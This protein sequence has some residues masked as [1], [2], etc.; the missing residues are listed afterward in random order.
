LILGWLILPVRPAEVAG[1]DLASRVV[2][3][4]NA[5]DPDSVRLARYYATKR[6][7]PPDN[8]V[9]LPMSAAET[10]GWP[11]FIGSIYQPLQDWLAARHWIDAI[12]TTVTDSIGRKRYSIFGHRISYLVVCRGVPLRVSHEPRFYVDE[13]Q[14]ASQPGLRTNQGAVDSE[15][16][17][18]AHGTYDINGWLPNPRFK[19]EPS[20]LF[21]TN[22]VVCVTRLDGPS[23]EDAAG[24]VDHAIEAETTGLIGRFYVNVRGGPHPDGEHWLEQTGALIADLGFDGDVDRTDNNLPVTARFDAPAFYFAWYAQ[25]LS[26]PMAPPDFRFPPGAIALHIHSA[27]APTL[28]STATGWCGPLVARGVTATFGNVFEPYLQ[29][30][31]EPQLLMQALGQGWNLGDAACFATPAL[32]WQTI[33]IGDPLYRP[34]AVPLDA[35]LANAEALVP[36]LK[37]YVLLRKARLLERE[38]RKAEAMQLLQNGI[39]RQPGAVLAL[40]LAERLGKDG[41]KRG[42]VRVLSSNFENKPL[43]PGQIPLHLQAARQLLDDGAAHQA[44]AVYRSILDQGAPGPVWREIILRAGTAAARAAGELDQAVAWEK[45]LSQ[46]T[47]PVPPGPKK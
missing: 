16:A 8:V 46:L 43:D 17:L 42:A 2:V 22:P 25:D 36:A 12:A 32:S 28:R 38:G 33:V 11:E 20:R 19:I 41:D 13:L 18:L 39:H 30:T 31:L 23:F 1:S 15:L 6:A 37:P 5:K 4:A 47:N 40:A 27:S 14:L 24:L 21:E 9:A 34:F 3:L 7:V 44:V 45:E 35:Q 26:G 10:I 29:L